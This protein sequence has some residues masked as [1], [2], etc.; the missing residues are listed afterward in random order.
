VHGAGLAQPVV[1]GVGIA[2]EA[3]AG[4]PVA[5]DVRG[6]DADLERARRRPGGDRSSRR[7]ARSIADAVRILGALPIADE[8]AQQRWSIA[9]DFL[10]AGAWRALAEHA[11][12]AW[13]AGELRPAAVGRGADRAL[14]PEIRGDRIA[15]ID[16][17]RCAPEVSSYL[18]RMEALRLELNRDFLGLLDFESHFAVYPAGERYALHADRFARDARRVL[19]TVLYLNAGWTPADGGALRLHPEGAAPVDVLPLGGTLVVFASDLAHEV[20]PARRVRLSLAGWFR[21]R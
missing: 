2:D 5:R 1:G 9:S 17:A 14:R 11:L 19:S 3:G 13:R 12:G 15:W 4:C 8:L 7:E 16:P 6:V 20:L 10:E 18:I 21:R